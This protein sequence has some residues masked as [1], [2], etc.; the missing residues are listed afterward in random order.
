MQA[1]DQKTSIETLIAKTAIA[2][3]VHGYALKVREGRGWSCGE[4][5]VDDAVFEVRNAITFG[6]LA[7]TTR[8]KIVGR[9]AI[10]ASI[11]DSTSPAAPVCPLISNLIIHLDG[12][13]ASSICVM[14]TLSASGGPQT[15]GEYRDRFRFA[16]GWRFAE[17]IFTI[18]GEAGA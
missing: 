16:D 2:D 17:R 6:A 12:F 8:Y 15:L 7:F 3:L 18:I 11:A 1:V 9:E 13:E 14:T 5:F 4:L 10:A